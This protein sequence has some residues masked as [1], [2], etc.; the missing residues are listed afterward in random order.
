VSH[1]ALLIDRLA[2][3]TVL[4]SLRA[5]GADVSRYD[6]GGHVTV[7]NENSPGAAITIAQGSGATASTRS[8]PGNLPATATDKGSGDNAARPGQ[9]RQALE[10]EMAGLREGEGYSAR[11]AEARAAP[12]QDTGE[13]LQAA[14]HEQSGRRT[15][16]TVFF[17]YAHDD[18]P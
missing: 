1:Y 6:R 13:R 12:E 8:G 18:E 4:D 7:R 3:E 16:A 2:F 11:E 9:Q 15:A 17:S 14:Q 10:Q 5:K